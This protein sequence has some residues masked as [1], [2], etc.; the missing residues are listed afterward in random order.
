MRFLWGSAVYQATEKQ[1][2]TVLERDDFRC[3]YCNRQPPEVSLELDH[4]HPQSQGGS[5]GLDNILTA[6]RDCNHGKG[7]RMLA[8]LPPFILRAYVCQAAL[9]HA[10]WGLIEVAK[11]CFVVW[12]RHG[13]EQAAWVFQ[14]H[15][16]AG[17]YAP[18]MGLDSLR[19]AVV[20][21]IE[22]KR[23]EDERGSYRTWSEAWDYF[24]DI[25]KKTV[26][27]TVTAISL[28]PRESETTG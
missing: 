25:C 20:L 17:C 14:T 28:Y 26:S 12:R 1:R 8:T 4:V 21:A 10:S 11:M 5:N 24:C 3:R 18:W 13:G 6:C 9:N 2:F 23:A 19:L 22:W 7:A 15:V 16:V 27:D